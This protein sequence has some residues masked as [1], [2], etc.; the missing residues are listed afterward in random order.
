MRFTDQSVRSLS[1]PASGQRDYSDDALPGFAVRVGKRTKTFI[2]TAG[3]R[4]NRA[5]YTIGRYNPPHFT[6]AI[7]REKA[8]DII[9]RERLRT[10]E[11]PRT[12]F[13]YALET[14]YRVHLSRLRP[15][16]ARNVRQSL[17]RHF[18]PRLGKMALA[19]I[20]RSDIAPILDTMLHIPAAM[21]S[22]FKFLRSFLNWC[23]QRGY[24]DASP[25]D[26]MEPPRRPESRSRVLLPD[27]LVAVWRAAPDS[28]YGRIVKLCILSAQRRGQ[29]GAC[30]REYIQGDAITWPAELMKG[31]RAHTVPLTPMMKALL[32]DR[33]GY[34]FPNA[35]IIAF[36]NWTRNKDRLDSESSVEGFRLH[37]LRRTWATISAEELDTP[38]HIIEAVLAHQ[39]GTA[40]ARTYN[41]AKYVEPMRKAMIAFEEWLQTLL[42]NTE[43]TNG[44]ELPRLH[45][46]RA[47]TAKWG[48]RSGTRPAARPS[49]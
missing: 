40:V 49:N 22:T 47:R 38:P 30:R 9:A 2:L 7:A 33:L 28:D 3:S 23:V 39:S 21:H 48:A 29:W 15:A 20:K 12:K 43:S 24:I 4:P 10:T 37:D 17:D 46:Q 25:T 14:Y 45:N 42:L 18:R 36:G 11:A 13:A 5:R 32:P 16:S 27:E 8:K 31:G 26:R 34:L 44:P 6:L 19:D 41:R 35:N 1:H